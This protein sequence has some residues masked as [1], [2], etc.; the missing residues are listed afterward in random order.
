[1]IKTKTFE[2]QDMLYLDTMDVLDGM[3]DMIIE[4][5]GDTYHF[6]G[7]TYPK[8][9]LDTLGGALVRLSDM[10]YQIASPDSIS[11]IELKNL[12]T[13]RQH[14]AEGLVNEFSRFI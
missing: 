1:M 8:V 6:D 5:L 9:I 13:Q 7:S 14:L 10:S 12:Y 11:Y 3:A 2:T 4:T